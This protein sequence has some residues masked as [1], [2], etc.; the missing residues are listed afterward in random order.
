MSMGV[1]G[2]GRAAGPALQSHSDL[3]RQIM[4][5]ALGAPRSGLKPKPHTRARNLA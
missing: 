2:P 3:E 5:A 4:S 1:C